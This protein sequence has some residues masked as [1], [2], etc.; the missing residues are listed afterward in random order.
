MELL[1]R[2][3]E[4]VRKHL[5]WQRQDDIIA[6]LRANLES[7]L[8]EKEEALGR[9]LTQA[10]TEEWLKKLGSPIQVAAG[11]QTHQYLIGPNIFPTYRYVLKLACSWATVIYSI[12][13]VVQAFA[14]QNAG[15]HALLDALLHLPYVLV[16]TAAWVTLVFA[17]IEYAV[18]KQY[19]KLP[20]MCAP[21]PGWSPGSLPPLG[22]DS[23]SGKKPRSYAQAVAEVVFGILFLGWLLMIPEHPFLLMGPGAYWLKASPFELAPVWVPFFWCVVALN[24]AQI[25][26]NIENLL[27]GRW[28]RPQPVKQAVFK[29]VGLA[30]MTILLTARDHVVVLLRNPAADHAQ[31]GETLHS[32]NDYIHWSAAVVCTIIA[33]QLGWEVVQ[34]ILNSYRKRVA[35]MQ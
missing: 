1:D 7:Q 12:V 28:Q 2:Y 18:A 35:A 15:G 27:R 23:A 20:A 34:L 30:P 19:L 14:T 5:P 32:I 25:G 22:Q 29:V 9:P 16:T 13:A 31:Y 11:Y 4:A 6:E 21:S 26:W 3:L 33:L 8:E 17:A 24:I 10:E